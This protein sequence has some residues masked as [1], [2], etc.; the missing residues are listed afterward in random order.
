[1]NAGHWNWRKVCFRCSCVLISR[2]DSF[3]VTVWTIV[4]IVSYYRSRNVNKDGM[5]DGEGHVQIVS[6]REAVEDKKS[7]SL[8]SIL[9]R[10]GGLVELHHMNDI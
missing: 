2:M 7:F 1:M 9:R 3:N 10:R 4:D 6:S 5:V 8:D